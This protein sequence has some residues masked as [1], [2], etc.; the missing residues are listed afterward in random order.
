MQVQVQETQEVESIIREYKLPK[1]IE[2]A[3]RFGIIKPDYT[4]QDYLIEAVE[5]G[6]Y[7]T[8]QLWGVQGSG[9]STRAIQMGHWIYKNYNTVLDNIIF[10]PSELVECLEALPEGEVIP[11]LIWDDV[12]V[13]YPSSKF[14]TDIQQYEAIDATWA[15]IRTKVNVIITTIPL[16]DR[17]AKNIKDNLTFEV[18]IGRNQLELINR[19]YHLPGIRSVESNFFKVSIEMPEPFDLYKVPEAVWR[20]YWKKRLRL[21]QEAL[22]VLRGVTDMEDDEGYMPVKDA[23]A[24]AGVSATTLQQH[25]SRGVYRGKKFKGILYILIEDLNLYLKTKDIPPIG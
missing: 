9:K 25:I 22:E 8:V 21:T 18:F 3:I 7:E 4:L 5:I 19:M 6:G 1:P 14:K 20:R 12:G 2:Q 24:E 23:A 10:R 17:L 15:A 11:C 13:H 16:I